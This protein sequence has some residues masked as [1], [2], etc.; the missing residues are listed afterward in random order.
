MTDAERAAEAEARVRE[1]EELLDMAGTG[2]GEA[3]SRVQELET[4]VFSLDCAHRAAES[5]LAWFKRR[6]NA[7]PAIPSKEDWR[8]LC[9]DMMANIEGWPAEDDAELARRGLR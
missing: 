4:H 8:A 9:V 7:L 2:K 5:R 6:Y 1:L 3:E